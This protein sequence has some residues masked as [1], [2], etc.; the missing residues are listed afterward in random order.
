[1]SQQSVYKPEIEGNP[2]RARW[3]N[4]RR[5]IME[6]SFFVLAKPVSFPSTLDFGPGLQK[7]P[8]TNTARVDFAQ[9]FADAQHHIRL[10]PPTHA[11]NS[12]VESRE[13]RRLADMHAARAA[14]NSKAP[15]SFEVRQQSIAL[16]RMSSF[17]SANMS[18]IRRLSRLPANYDFNDIMAT[19]GKHAATVTATS[20][21]STSRGHTTAPSSVN[22]TN[23]Q[24]LRLRGNT[25]PLPAPQAMR[26]NQQTSSLEKSIPLSYR[27][28]PLPILPV[29]SHEVRAQTPA[30]SSVPVV[31]DS[32]SGMTAAMAHLNRRHPPR[33]NTPL[34]ASPR[35]SLALS[36]ASSRRKISG[37][38][39]PVPGM[40]SVAAGLRTLKLAA[41]VNGDELKF[42]Q[43]QSAAR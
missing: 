7:R 39:A 43:A 28:S 17:I 16:K 37:D 3:Q 9:I 12:D 14:A 11:P 4:V 2:A 33:S 20:P 29:Q 18:N 13:P 26:T 27:R 42:Q 25:S 21:S 19:Y 5:K 23:V 32:A 35:A 41:S 8:L 34:P 6:G 15:S 40:P 36:A 38:S 1:M 10:S 31:Q 22:S 24:G 30:V